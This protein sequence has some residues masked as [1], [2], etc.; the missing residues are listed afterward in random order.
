MQDL[1]QGGGMIQFI[2]R[3]QFLPPCIKL[4]GKEDR[5]GVSGSRGQG[6]VREEKEPQESQ[7]ERVG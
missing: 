2:F 1:R 4:P 6:G 5:L 7:L 3:R